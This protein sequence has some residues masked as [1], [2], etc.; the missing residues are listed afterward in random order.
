[1]MFHAQVSIRG[2]VIGFTIREKKFK[3]INNPTTE[4]QMMMMISKLEDLEFNFDNDLRKSKF[5]KMVQRV[6]TFVKMTKTKSL[7]FGPTTCVLRRRH[8]S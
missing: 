8:G 7:L 4:E 3:S 2:L 6:E 1:M 5:I